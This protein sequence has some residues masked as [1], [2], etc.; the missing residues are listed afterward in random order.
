MSLTCVSSSSFGVR[1]FSGF[2]DHINVATMCLYEY[3]YAPE[4]Y[5]FALCLI[6]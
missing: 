3:V 1:A 6:A 4:D 5:S 2:L